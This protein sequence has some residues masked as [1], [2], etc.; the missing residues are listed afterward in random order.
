MPSFPGGCGFVVGVANYYENDLN[1]KRYDDLTVKEAE[2]VTKRLTDPNV[3]GY[4]KDRV[5]TVIDPDRKTLL[6][7]FGA[8]VE[9]VKNDPDTK[10]VVLFF[11]GHGM[12][13]TDDK[14]Y[15]TT[16]E[17]RLNSG[18]V[19]AG[20]GG[21][22]SDELMAFLRVIP[23]KKLLFILDACFSGETTPS[24]GGSLGE[25]PSRD[26]G[27]EFLATGEGRALITACKASQRSYFGRGTERTFFGGSLLDALDGE[28]IPPASGY[29]G[30]FEMYLSL[31]QGVK[32]SVEA[33]NLEQDPELTLIGGVGPFPI[34]LNSRTDRSLGGSV[35]ETK[36]LSDLPEDKRASVVQVS[37]GE[38]RPALERVSAMKAE[39][40]L[41]RKLLDYLK[42]GTT[43]VTKV[44]GSSAGIIV[45]SGGRIGSVTVQGDNIGRDKITR[46]EVG[47]PISPVEG[48]TPALLA[49][50]DNLKTSFEAL[51]GVLKAGTYRDLDHE[52][53]EAS[54]A[55]KDRDKDRCVE[56]LRRAMAYVQAEKAGSSLQ[57]SIGQALE[58]VERQKL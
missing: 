50:V 33:L 14:Y 16:K 9:Q 54:S 56:K 23:G 18:R 38:L 27:A 21:L 6:D 19:A 5:I 20:S 26:V 39:S 22:S 45:A 46:I 8:F 2:E 1:L 25:P 28:G 35:D 48:T 52:L 49:T 30:L 40:E 44:E 31:Y 12:K 13:G 47:S 41:V 3:C 32:G 4:P 29:V 15:F 17:V 34:A 58:M 37:E 57:V 11:A 51:K 53:S 42:P 24:L 55:L 7:A 43:N 36:L 10:T